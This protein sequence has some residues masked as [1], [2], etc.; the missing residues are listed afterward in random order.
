MIILINRAICFTVS[1]LLAVFITGCGDDFLEEGYLIN[2]PFKQ[3][4]R[5]DFRWPKKY[6]DYVRIININD[7][8]L[9]SLVTT[10]NIQF[11]TMSYS[12]KIL[13]QAAV[14][15]YSKK[16]KKFK[17][18]KIYEETKKYEKIIIHYW[19]ERSMGDMPIEITKKNGDK[20]LK[21]VFTYTIYPQPDD[22]NYEN[23][24]TYTIGY[25]EFRGVAEQVRILLFEKNDDFVATFNVYMKYNLPEYV[26]P[27]RY[28]EA[29]TR[30]VIINEIITFNVKE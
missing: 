12:N 16:M 28:P 26:N 5:Y 18:D 2:Y 17:Q 9:E 21:P 20:K 15:D 23:S 10:T 24:F 6:Y 1:I 29:S 3:I 4:K 27:P 8:E 22:K 13:Y 14:N 25:E 19:G 7:K 30:S 11:N